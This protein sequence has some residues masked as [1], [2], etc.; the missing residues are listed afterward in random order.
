[1][2]PRRAV[3]RGLGA[4]GVGLPLAGCSAAPG[5]QP[6][7]TDTDSGKD[8]VRFYLSPSI[9]EAEKRANYGGI[10]RYLESELAETVELVYADTYARVLEALNGGTAH[11]AD[12]G[13]LA[14][15]LGVRNEQLAIGVQRYGRGSWSYGSVL[16]T[17]EDSDIRTVADV[18]GETVAMGDQLST[19]GALMPLYMLAEGGLDIGTYPNGD[20][21]D[22][23]FQATFTS[24]SD[25]WTML[26]EGDVAVAGVGKFIT[27]GESGEVRDGFRYV[28]QYQRIPNPPFATSPTLDAERE[29]RLV[30]LLDEAP[31]S[32]FHGAD[33]EAG[34][35]DDPWFSDLRPAATEQY[36]VVVDAA[37]TI[38]VRED[39]LETSG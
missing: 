21:S 1:M 25:A 29:Q 16:V 7:G 18:A 5:D 15:A 23:A 27:V 12:V 14:A 20:G 22:A 6:G 9:P 35:D 28:D 8:T 11:L 30:S 38:D 2:H 33:G 31:Q 36:Q 32:A 19:S 10:S 39:L 13:S 26:T 17:S 24:H 4:V 37:K 34:T 3:L